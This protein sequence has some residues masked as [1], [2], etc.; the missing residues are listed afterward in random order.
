MNAVAGGA[1]AGLQPERL[2]RAAEAATGLADWGAPAFLDGLERFCRSAVDEAGLDEARLGS[3]TAR[4]HDNLVK[5]LAL[6]ADRARYPVIAR[7]EIVA[8]LVVTGL[9]RSGT[10]ILHAL[11][12]QDPAVRSPQ[13]WELSAISPPPRT[14]TYRT[15][16][17]IAAGQAQIDALPAQFKAMHAMGATLP[18]ECNSI[19]TMA[20]RSPNFGAMA[21]V[22][23]YMDWLLHEADMTPAFEIHRHVLQHLQAFAPGSR[24]VLKAPPYLF[25][26]VDLFAAYPDAK[27][28]MTH[29]DPAEVIP[30]NASLV[31]FLIGAQSEAARSELGAAQLEMWALGADRMMAYREGPG[32]GRQIIDVHYRNFIKDQIGFVAGIYAAFGLDFTDEARAAMTAFIADNEQGKHGSHSYSAQ[33]FGLDDE[34]VRKRFAAYL[35]K[36]DV[37]RA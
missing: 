32:A 26:P 20:F 10:T 15:D 9:P 2:C 25:W 23:G 28:V 13:M 37:M 11:L 34:R 18:E 12:A 24:W 31:G 3:V 16:P 7:Q 27:V 22:P 14:E 1:A 29:R 4:I 8:P 5:R 35:D 6:Y 21:R 30:S 17:R 36:F 19:M 33:Q